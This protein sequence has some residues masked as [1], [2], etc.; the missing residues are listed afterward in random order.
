MF[1]MPIEE[2]TEAEIDAMIL[3]THIKLRCLLQTFTDFEVIHFRENEKR[4]RRFFAA[5]IAE[6]ELS[7]RQGG[8]NRSRPASRSW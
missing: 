1:K 4:K 2:L 3:K 5:E 6:Q 7:R 8:R